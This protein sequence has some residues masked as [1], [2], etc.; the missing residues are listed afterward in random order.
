MTTKE[1]F[2]KALEAAKNSPVAHDEYYITIRHL[3]NVIPRLIGNV[4]EEIEGMERRLKNNKTEGMEGTLDA[5]NDVL[6]EID[7]IAQIIREQAD[8]ENFRPMCDL[9]YYAKELEQ[10]S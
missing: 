8:Y 5:C 2:K 9:V 6:C 7:T 1:E 10:A 4:L 3:C